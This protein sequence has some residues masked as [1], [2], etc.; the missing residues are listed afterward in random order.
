[1]TKAALCNLEEYA[2]AQGESLMDSL[3]AVCQQ[4]LAGLVYIHNFSGSHDQII[5]RDVKPQNILVCLV[6][7]KLKLK[8]CDAGDARHISPSADPLR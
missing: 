2:K 5:H 7:D 6:N 8:Y 3:Y 1:V 4:S